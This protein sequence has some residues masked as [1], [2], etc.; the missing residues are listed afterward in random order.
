MRRLNLW[1]GDRELTDRLLAKYLRARHDGKV[2]GLKPTAPGSIRSF[3]SAVIFR[4]VETW[5]EPSTIGKRTKRMLQYIR[6]DVPGR[7]RGQARHLTLE[8][9]E[10][11]VRRDDPGRLVLGPARRSD[12]QHHVLLRAEGL[13]GLPDPR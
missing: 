1:R 8:Q 6:R 12:D 11:M 9:V 2:K 10:E 3:L 4:Y 7:G 13:G 5:K